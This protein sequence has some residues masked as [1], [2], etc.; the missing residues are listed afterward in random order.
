VAPGGNH[1]TSVVSV[2]LARLDGEI[3]GALELTGSAQGTFDELTLAVAAEVGRHVAELTVTAGLLPWLTAAVRLEPR[4]I[5]SST[6]DDTPAGNAILARILATALEILGADRGWILL[7]DSSMD[8]LYTTL[9]EGLG[10]RE[11]RVGAH[12]GVAGACF[13]TGEMV[14]IAQA[15]QD[16]RFNPAVDFQIGYRTRSILCTPIFGG[17][18]QKLGVLQVVNRRNGAFDAADEAHLRALASQMGVTLDYT[19][20]F[21]QV[22][23]MKSHN[24]SMLRSLT[25]GVLTID[26]RG[27]VSFV[28]Q[29]ALDILRRTEQ[30]VLGQPLMKVF[31]EMNAWILEA[32]DEVAG[33]LAEK[34]LPNNEFYI[35]SL[36]DWVSANTSLLPL[37]DSKR[38]S[39]GFMLVIESLEREREWRRTMSRYISNEIIDRLM[40]ESGGTLGGTAQPATTLFSDIRGFT[41]LSEQ[42]GPAGTVSMLNEYFSYME[43][44]LTNRSGIIDK[45]VG[46][47]IMAV[48]G[49]PTAGENDAQSAVTAAIEMLQVLDLLN[50]RRAEAS[51]AMPIRI[52]VGLATGTVIAGNIGSPKRMDF[53]V[54][55]DAVNLASR[56]ES[57]TKQYGADILIC[58]QTL[59]RLTSS[60]RTRRIDV[61]RVRGQTRPTA[62]FEILDHRAA[63]WTPEFA[64]AIGLYEQGLDAYIAGSWS[65]A[66]QHFQASLSLRSGDKAAGMMIDRCLRFQKL[67]P[68]NWDGVSD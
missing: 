58:E 26:M 45:Y 6:G 64:Q 31:G 30:E 28:N 20:L 19:G 37:R 10:S 51:G 68:A 39:L 65:D 53:T 13:R 4:E 22:L 52:G 16:P 55:G 32:I 2:P 15:Y 67:P 1:D 36:G 38:N 29:A 33:G 18:G 34:V 9:S 43:D 42:L 63:E 48:F 12:D 46:D 41:T 62:L 27:E 59:K 60:P 5:L 49:L 7:Y 35:E 23:R 17:D 3:V 14:N 44:V 54:I 8:E 11:L 47:A 56:I 50:R 61:V 40:E 25:N 21:D 24:E 66:Q 57:M